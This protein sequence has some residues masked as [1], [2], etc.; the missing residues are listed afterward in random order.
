MH[1]TLLQ[2]RGKTR[3]NENRPTTALTSTN[4]S[5]QETRGPSFRTQPK[6]NSSATVLRATLESGRPSTVVAQ[7]RQTAHTKPNF[8]TTKLHNQ[9]PT[10][11]HTPPLLAASTTTALL[12]RTPPKYAGT[13]DIRPTV[14][15]AHSGANEATRT[16]TTSAPRVETS[17]RA[18]EPPW[19][20][21]QTVAARKLQTGR[22]TEVAGVQPTTNAT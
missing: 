20:G 2:Q 7:D 1:E 18:T 21:W 9:P 5:T 13:R 12:P 11:A 15:G 16:L 4:V 22:E 6:L 3:F 17:N 8:A 19:A 14:H 10:P